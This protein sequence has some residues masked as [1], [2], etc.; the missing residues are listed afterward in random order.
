[1][2]STKDKPRITPGDYPTHDVPPPTLTLQ[3]YVWRLERRCQ[4]LEARNGD[5]LD[6][7]R[8]MCNDPTTPAWMKQAIGDVING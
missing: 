3:S 7:L 4:V 1:M 2:Y 6:R 8:A 5:I